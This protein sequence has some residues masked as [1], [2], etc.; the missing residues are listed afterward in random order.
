MAPEIAK[1]LLDAAADLRDAVDGMQFQTAAYTYNP[2]RYAWEPYASYITK[3]G[4]GRAGRTLLVGMNPGPWGM[5]QTGVPFGDPVMVRDW[6]GIKGSVEPFDGAYKRVPVM[7][8]SSHRRERSGTRLYSW[9]KHRFGSADRFFEDFFVLNYFPLLLLTKDGKNL[10]PARLPRRE[11]AIVATTCD[12]HLRFYMQAI[13]PRCVAGFGHYAAEQAR[14]V[15]EQLGLAIPVPYL[16]H[17]S[18]ASPRANQ[19]WEEL[20]EAELSAAGVALPS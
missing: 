16:L 19:N 13:K 4:P 5:A 18:P 15:V 17:P 12:S 10:T 20:A 3:Y 11:R 8:F 2:L 14:R 6:L 7:G 1:S 9:A